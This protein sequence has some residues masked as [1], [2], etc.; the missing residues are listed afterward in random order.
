MNK[1]SLS[2]L[3]VV[4]SLS[5]Q[6]QISYPSVDKGLKFQAQDESALIKFSF[7]AQSLFDYSNNFDGNDEEMKAMVRRARLKFGGYLFNPKYEYKV[8][9]GLSNRDIG[10]KRDEAQ[11]NNASRIILD[12]VFKYHMGN[13]SQIWFGQTKLP[14]NRE[15]VISS[16]ALQF[17]D[18]TNVNSKFNIDRDFGVQYRYKRNLGEAPLF[19]AAA[20]TAGE[21]RNITIVNNGGLSYTGRVEIHPLGAFQKKGAY[22]SSDL[23][24]EEKPRLAIGA[25][26]CFNQQTDRSQGQLGS[27]VTDSNGSVFNDLTS[28]FVDLMFKYQGWSVQSVYAK[29]DIASKVAGYTYGDGFAAQ[30]G[31]LFD[32]NM[33]VSARY[34]TVSLA[35]E[36]GAASVS[37]E[38]TL[39]L[40]NYIVA[41]KVK[42]Q[43]DFSLINDNDYRFRF[44]LEFGI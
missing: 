9:L 42:W 24:R 29:R 8:E 35:E 36:M 13:H 4:A 43:T 25:S 28:V 41:H 12:A 33:E 5:L 11:V 40:S 17:V 7:R 6:A 21:G 34:T 26:Y 23:K 16:M 22:F 44:Q 19:L 37:N 18:R 32:N 1:L 39:G 30:A 27:F 10:N 14:G 31:Y 38:Y 3:L 20:V 2:I 15:R